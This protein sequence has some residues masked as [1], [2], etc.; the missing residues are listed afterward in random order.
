[1]LRIDECRPSIEQM[2]VRV[3]RIIARYSIYEKLS[4]TFLHSLCD[5]EAL[6]FKN[7][8]SRIPKTYIQTKPRSY[9]SRHASLPNLFE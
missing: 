7:Q 6:A 2:K 3:K 4:E 9:I 1:M 8:V 5:T